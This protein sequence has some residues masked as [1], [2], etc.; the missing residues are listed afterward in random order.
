MAVRN[1]RRHVMDELKK[2]E[3]DGGISQDEHRDYGKEIQDLTDHFIT[4]MDEALHRKEQE[5]MQV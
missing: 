5:I 2:T 1:V 4:K 3:K